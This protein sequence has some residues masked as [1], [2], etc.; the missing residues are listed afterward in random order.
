M[1]GSNAHTDDR[2]WEQG[3]KE[4]ADPSRPL[5]NVNTMPEKQV[6]NRTWTEVFGG[7]WESQSERWSHVSS[8]R[9]RR[10][11]CKTPHVLL[12][13]LQFP[14]CPF[15][16]GTKLQPPASSHLAAH[17]SRHSHNSPGYLGPQKSVCAPEGN[18]WSVWGTGG[19]PDRQGKEGTN[20]EQRINVLSK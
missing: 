2:R 5:Q 6:H 15:Q 14:Q 8:K 9:G 16:R 3:Q 20:S 4:R 19:S 18:Q 13:I 17:G 1:S 10:E 7:K 12:I 11:Q